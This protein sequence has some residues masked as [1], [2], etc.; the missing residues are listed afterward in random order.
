MC[1]IAHSW[2]TKLWQRPQI[3]KS[4]GFRELSDADG[5]QMQQWHDSL[6]YFQLRRIVQY[7][8]RSHE[9]YAPNE[10]MWFNRTQ[11]SV[12]D[13]N[14]KSYTH[15]LPVPNNIHFLTLSSNPVKYTFNTLSN[16]IKNTSHKSKFQIMA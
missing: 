16:S 15:L 3:H 5:E 2:E 10:N 11:F 7:I 9:K 4:L 6:T 1:R 12:G 13:R 8:H 14:Q